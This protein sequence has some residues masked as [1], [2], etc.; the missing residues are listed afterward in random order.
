MATATVATA[1]NP[2][3]YIF[4]CAH[5]FASKQRAASSGY[6]THLYEIS[7]AYAKAHLKYP[8]VWNNTT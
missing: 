6:N 8:L 4:I 1:D 7:S 3:I 5:S 2:D